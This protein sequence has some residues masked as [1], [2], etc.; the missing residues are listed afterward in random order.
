MALGQ[1]PLRTGLIS[2]SHIRIRWLGQYSP[3]LVDITFYF[4]VKSFNQ[5]PSLQA[6]NYLQTRRLSD[7]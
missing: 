5:K 7:F 3:N 2:F 4:I 1:Q 6:G